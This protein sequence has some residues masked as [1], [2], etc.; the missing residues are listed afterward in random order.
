ME[1]FIISLKWCLIVGAYKKLLYLVITILPLINT[2]SPSLFFLPLPPPWPSRAAPACS[3][4]HA[5]VLHAPGA[6]LLHAAR[7]AQ[8]FHKIHTKFKQIFTQ[9]FVQI[10]IV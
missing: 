9:I 7:W 6:V 3:A 4:L 5:C 8:I 1:E 10:Y 2:F